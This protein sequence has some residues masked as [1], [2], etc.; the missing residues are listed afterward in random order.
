MAGSVCSRSVPAGFLHR[1]SHCGVYWGARPGGRKGHPRERRDK[2]HLP[3]NAP[4]ALD[5]QLHEARKPHWIQGRE[6]SFFFLC[7]QI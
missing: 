3:G 7:P 5:A 2:S 6:A 1:T 4:Q